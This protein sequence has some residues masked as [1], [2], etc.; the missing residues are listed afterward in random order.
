MQES[1]R[2]WIFSWPEWRTPRGRGHST[3]RNDGDPQEQHVQLAGMQVTTRER[4]FSYLECRTPRERRL[5]AGWNEGDPQEQDVQLAR[6]S[7]NLEGQDSQLAAIQKTHRNRTFSKRERTFSWLEC[8]RPTGTEHS[9][10]WN[11]D[12]QEG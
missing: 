6:I 10:G 7:G 11:A 2:E 4:T 3:G 8:R 5:S 1:Q 12:N 9:G